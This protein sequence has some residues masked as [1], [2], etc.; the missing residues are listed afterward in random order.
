M[1]KAPAKPP[2]KPGKWYNILARDFPIKK[3]DKY[4]IVN[5]FFEALAFY[6]TLQFTAQSKNEVAATLTWGFVVTMSFVCL[7]WAC[8]Q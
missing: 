7:V 1:P 5:L 3:L 2:A 6:F 8:R 4:Q